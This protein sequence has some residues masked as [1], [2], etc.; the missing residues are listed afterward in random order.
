[1]AENIYRVLAPIPEIGALPGDVLVADPSDP[2]FPF[3]LSRS[4]P[5]GVMP[6]VGDSRLRPV[7]AT[8]AGFA[9]GYARGVAYPPARLTQEPRRTGPTLTV[10][11]GGGRQR[12]TK[13]GQRP[14]RAALRLI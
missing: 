8:A 14:R 10:A 2:E 11:A 12:R 6:I 9:D 13:G 3:V 4:L 5:R 1:M 7:D